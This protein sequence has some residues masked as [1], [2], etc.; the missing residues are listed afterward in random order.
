M[1]REGVAINVLLWRT[2]TPAIVIVAVALAALVYNRLYATILDGF[3]RTLATT[4]SLTGALLD[5]GDHDDLMAIWKPGADPDAIE[6]TPLYI[7]NVLP[8]RRIKRELELTYLYSQVVGGSKDIYYVLDASEGDDHSQI[9]AEDEM[10]PETLAGLKA[11]TADGDVYISPI[12]FQEQW[13]LL[14]TAAAPIRGRDGR[15]TAT[16]GADVNISVIQVAS[17]NALFASALIGLASL[18][19]CALVTLMIMR[20]VAQPLAQLKSDALR[21]AAGDRAPPTATRAPREVARLR[22]ALGDLAEHLIGAMR[23]ARAAAL[24][25]DRARNLDVLEAALAAEREGPAVVVA[26][27]SRT[28]AVWIDQAGAGAAGLL[29]RRAMRALAA[30]LAA[31]PAGGPDWAG[32]ASAAEGALLVVDRRAANLRLF[33]G[34]PLDVRIGDRGVTLSPGDSA[35]LERGAPLV[36]VPPSGPVPLA[37]EARG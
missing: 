1:P 8:L 37:W 36:A 27:T 33:G 2:F 4:S 6:K 29:G 28:F 26:D 25:H 22:D 12:E 5:P 31:D 7:R 23:R 9:G 3:D 14:K 11:A 18:L 30:R 24:D 35:P 21:I 19:A 16:A 10:T 17:Q 32:L 34:A 20:R 13:G 15:I